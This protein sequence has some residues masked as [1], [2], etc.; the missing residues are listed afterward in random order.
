MMIITVLLSSI[1]LMI[2]IFVSVDESV[3]C[4]GTVEP[5]DNYKIKSQISAIISAI[6]ISNGDNINP[7]DILMKF[8]NDSLQIDLKKAELEF[9]IASYK[10]EQEK[11]DTERVYNSKRRLFN[12]GLIAYDEYITSK[13]KFDNLVLQKYELEKYHLNILSLSNISERAVVKANIA[14][15]VIYD[16]SKIFPGNYLEIGSDLFTI[17][18]SKNYNLIAKIMIPEK[19]SSR[20]KLSNTVKIFITAYPYTKYKTLDGL[21]NF[22]SPI[23][24]NGFLKGKV[25]LKENTI[26]V[27]NI[28]KPL[29]Y[30]MT[31]TAKII[32]GKKPIIKVL[33]GIKDD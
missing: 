31:L 25:I 7:G 33:L 32:I 23:S 19:S 20:I 5:A 24:E 8:D 29:S 18:D 30:G 26:R 12:K 17:L 2:S 15:K 1:L 16:E 10:Y 22:I 3:D 27:D 4:T 21:L 11:R 28:D 13:I 9:Q 6:F 14:G